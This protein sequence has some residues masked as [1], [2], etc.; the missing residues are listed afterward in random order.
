LHSD[1]VAPGGELRNVERG[2]KKKEK[3][4]DDEERAFDMASQ[5]GRQT[6]KNQSSLFIVF[7]TILICVSCL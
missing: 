4:Y 3:I 5:L 2:I 7:I 6:K 1:G